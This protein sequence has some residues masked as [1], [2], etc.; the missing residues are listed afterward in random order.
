VEH[1]TLL[2]GWPTI[3]DSNKKMLKRKQMRPLNQKRRNSFITGGNCR[4]ASLQWG[5]PAQ[6]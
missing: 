3:I 4:T 6:L 2:T 5:V 1:T